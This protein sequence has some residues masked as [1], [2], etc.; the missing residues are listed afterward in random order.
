M[1][2]VIAD[3]DK[4]VGG[5]GY[6]RNPPEMFK[7]GF[8]RKLHIVPG[9]RKAVNRLLKYRGLEV[10]ILTKP[11]T[12]NLNSTIEKYLWIEEH[13]PK[14]LKRMFLAHDKGHFN[15]DFLIDDDK[16]AWGKKFSGVFLHFDRFNPEKSWEMMLEVLK[17]YK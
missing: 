6:K 3:F 17:E 14:L 15:G 2:G 16:K 13:F 10:H 5:P 11:S 8:F 1:D 12:K 4:A 7:K 9:A